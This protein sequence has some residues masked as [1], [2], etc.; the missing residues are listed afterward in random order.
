[1]NK[2]I[3]SVNLV[4]AIVLGLAV[5]VG[6]V[7][8]IASPVAA[9]PAAPALGS[10]QA[11]TNYFRNVAIK[12]SDNSVALSMTLYT[13]PTVNAL[14]INDSTGA[15]LFTIGPDGGVTAETLTVTNLISQ[16]VGLNQDVVTI[17]DLTSTN[18]TGTLATAAQP[19]VTSLGT[20]P[21]ATITNLTS[22]NITGTLATASQPNVTNLGTQAYFTATNST[23]DV[24]TVGGLVFTYTDPITI[25]GVLTDVRLLFYQV[26]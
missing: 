10:A 3:T 4:V 2:Q 7:A 20:L 14:T 19:N 18:I 13:T 16:T 25:S 21:L 17:A 11:V 24:I 6:I 23:L 8:G 9:P 15:A 22:T 5:V 1:M 26:P 12:P